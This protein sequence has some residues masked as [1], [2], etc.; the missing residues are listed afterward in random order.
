M[1]S[2]IGIYPD[3]ISTYREPE[4]SGPIGFIRPYSVKHEDIINGW[5]CLYGNEGT[6][7]YFVTDAP[8]EPMQ[9]DT[10]EE[11]Y[12]TMAKVRSCLRGPHLQ[13]YGSYKITFRNQTWDKREPVVIEGHG[14]YEAMKAAGIDYQDTES[15]IY[16]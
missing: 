2:L 13:P 9:G 11:L 1:I 14:P 10:L 6:G 8:I 12:E 15:I 5:L 16:L 4:T 3:G 7:L